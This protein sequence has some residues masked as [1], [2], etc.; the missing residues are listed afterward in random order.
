MSKEIYVNNADEQFNKY[1]NYIKS[2]KDNVYESFK[3]LN[4]IFKIIFP[5]VYTNDKIITQLNINM[6]MHDNSKYDLIEFGPYA[7][8]FFPIKGYQCNPKDP[9]YKLAWLHHI[10]N[11]PHHPE[12]WVYWD[13]GKDVILDMEDIYIIEMLCDWEAMSMYFG[14]KT[15]D[16]YHEHGLKDHPF[17]ERTKRKLEEYFSYFE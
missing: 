6:S 4:T 7:N 11:N 9:K 5:D 14:T 10:H 3:K 13:D 17:S 8:R 15:I 1:S 2:H 12:H 16:Y